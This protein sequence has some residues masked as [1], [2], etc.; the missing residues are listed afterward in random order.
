MHKTDK[1]NLGWKGE[2]KRDGV[3]VGARTE[4]N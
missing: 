4:M 1:L 3:K 2:E